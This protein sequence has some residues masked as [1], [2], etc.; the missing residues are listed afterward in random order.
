M[1]GFF[2]LFLSIFDE[3]VL[4]RKK[5]KL[6]AADPDLE[7]RGGGGGGGSVMIFLPCWTFSLQ[8][9]LISYFFTRA[10]P[11]DPL[12]KFTYNWYKMRKGILTKVF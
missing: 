10:P 11:Q 9:F 1:S 5:V 6:S 8:S 3:V 4:L 12:L 2:F 7:Q